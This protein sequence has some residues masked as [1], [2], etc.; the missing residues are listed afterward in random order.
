MAAFLSG[1]KNRFTL[2][3]EQDCI[4]DLGLSKDEFEI[5]SSRHAAQGGEVYQQHLYIDLGNIITRMTAH[6]SS[7]Y[8]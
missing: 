8:G 4:V 1:L 7:A 2:I 5:L 6:K 3:E